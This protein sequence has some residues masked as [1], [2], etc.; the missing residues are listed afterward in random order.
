MSESPSQVQDTLARFRAGDRAA[1]DRLVEHFHARL[2]ALAH[3]LRAVDRM[4]RWVET[5][6]IVNE[7][8]IRLL[9]ALETERPETADRFY[10]LAAR[11]LRLTLTD[12]ARK[13]FGPHG[14]GANHATDRPRPAGDT[15][16]PPAYEQADNHPEPAS[17]LE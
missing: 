13:A 7:A 8:M 11:H 5:G 17:L 4:A 2:Q 15:A 1:R 10:G 16:P 9:R 6:D 3:K 12:M 14:Y